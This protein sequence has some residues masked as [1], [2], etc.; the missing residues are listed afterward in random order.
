L[1]DG[2]I[3]GR[4]TAVSAISIFGIGANLALVALQRYNRARMIQNVNSELKLGHVFREGYENYLGIDSRAVDNYIITALRQN[5]H[6]KHA[7]QP[8]ITDE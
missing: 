4:G 6:E 8:N 5:W 7:A 2:L 3:E 1:A